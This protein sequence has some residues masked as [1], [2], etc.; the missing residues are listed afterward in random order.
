[1]FKQ[2]RILNK[3]TNENF[4][5][6][7]DTELVNVS[8]YELTEIPDDNKPY[9][10]QDGQI[11]L[12]LK[13]I[14]DAKNNQD[15]I[16]CTIRF[17]QGAVING[18]KLDIN[19]EAKINMLAKLS[20]TPDGQNIDWMDFDWNWFTVTKEEFVQLAQGVMDKIQA[21]YEKRAAN[22]EA[23]AKPDLTL[24]ELEAIDIDYSKI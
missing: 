8:K 21:I 6:Q 11:K 22:V 20:M 7:I 10:W 14:I 3:N 9:I 1:M 12:H 19:T 2:C 4:Y 5:G 18:H 13:L 17:T 16:N 23:F 15:N 24:E